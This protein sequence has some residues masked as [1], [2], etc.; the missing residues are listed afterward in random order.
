MTNKILIKDAIIFTCNEN[1]EVYTKSNLLIKDSKIEAIECNL[2]NINLEE[3]VKIIE[4]QEMA[5]IPGIIN[6]HTHVAGAMF[7]GLID[8]GQKGLGLYNIGF[9][10]EKLLTEE[11]LYWLFLIGIAEVIKTGVTLVN[12]FYYQMDIFAEIVKKI[13][14]RAII[15]DTL[16][17]TDMTKLINGQYERDYQAGE[18]RL[19]KSVDI[20]EKW[21]DKSSLINFRIGPHATDTCSKRL[22][23]NAK[24]E[25][26]RMDVGLHMHCAQSKIEVEHIKKEHNKTPIKYLE[27]I[28]LLKDNI[29]LAHCHYMGEADWDIMKEHDVSYAHCPIVYAKNG[30]QYPK[31]K[32][33]LDNDIKTGFGTDWIRM[34]P[35]DGMRTAINILRSIERNPDIMG[36]RQVLKLNT[37]KAA[38][39]LSHEEKIGSIEIGKKADLA[40]ID[41]NKPHL[42]PFYG[43]PSGLVYY[44]NGNDVDT[45]IID[46]RIIMQNRKLLTINEKQILKNI[47][48]FIPV[49][50]KR[51]EKL[52]VNFPNYKTR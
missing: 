17:D 20:I 50:I 1:D 46:G 51:A 44:V 3:F 49:W 43:N 32:Y 38:E 34:E 30:S 22:L 36:G 31:L 33:A 5:V 7:R 2:K 48:K 27:E 16:Y 12:D 35:W 52:G 45:V 29:L 39:A 21:K 41:M 6:S 25:A 28:G 18:N 24:K 11:E 8:E 9:P 4:A 40:L 23:E 37:I 15:S 42:Q 26:N 10:M 19:Q 13:G 47:K 14:I